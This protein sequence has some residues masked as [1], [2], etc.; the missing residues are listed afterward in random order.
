MLAQL[1][2]PAWGSFLPGLGDPPHLLFHKILHLGLISEPPCHLAVLPTLNADVAPPTVATPALSHPLLSTHAH[3]VVPFP[4]FVSTV[5]RKL[6]IPKSL[7]S[8]CVLPH[9]QNLL[10]LLFS[11]PQG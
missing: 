7:S 4:P 8:L 1:T 3:E 5:I 6:T 10:P 11:Q 9:L 2:I